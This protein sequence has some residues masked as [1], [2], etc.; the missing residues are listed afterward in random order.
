MDTIFEKN[1]PNIKFKNRLKS[2]NYKTIIYFFIMHNIITVICIPIFEF[3]SSFTFQK[4][5][6]WDYGLL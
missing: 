2:V 4:S 1:E 6:L 5:F 3:S